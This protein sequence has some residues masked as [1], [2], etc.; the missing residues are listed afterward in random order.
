MIF[1]APALVFAAITMSQA[2]IMPGFLVSATLQDGKTVSGSFPYDTFEFVAV[3]SSREVVKVSIQKSSER[4]EPNV[5]CEI[6]WLSER[7]LFVIRQ[8]AWTGELVRLWER[9]DL[10]GEDGSPVTIRGEDVKK[11]RFVYVDRVH[12]TL[13]RSH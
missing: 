6:E 12:K 2:R 3:S 10:L 7:K 5:A 1:F 4:P 8:P 11:I 9:L 13:A